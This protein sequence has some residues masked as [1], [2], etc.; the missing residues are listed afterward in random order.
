MSNTYTQ[1]HIHIVFAV[2]NR[3]SLIQ[4]GWKNRLYQYIIGIIQNN[5]HKVIQ[6]NGM[7]DHIH[8]LIGLRPLQ[9]L[10]KLIQAVKRDSSSWVNQQ[11][12]IKSRFSWQEGYGAFSYA[13]SDVPII[14]RYIKNQEE[15]H[16]EKTFIQEYT[17]LLDEFEIDYEQQYI[18]KPII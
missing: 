6:I 7:R 1:I 17:D 18:F 5:G 8:I 12:F 4:P 13:K 10:S 14:A 15:H 9:S 3:Q 16:Q 11:K 2:K